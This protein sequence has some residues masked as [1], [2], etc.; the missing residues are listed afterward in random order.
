M[1]PTDKRHYESIALD[2]ENL[3]VTRVFGKRL[4]PFV[5]LLL[6]SI[7]TSQGTAHYMQQ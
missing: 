3:I 6:V 5:L 2:S 7:T 1:R 4:T